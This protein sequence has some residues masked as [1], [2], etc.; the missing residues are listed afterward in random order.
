MFDVAE[1]RK[2]TAALTT[3]MESCDSGEGTECADLDASL[4]HYAGLCCELREAIRQW[5][6]AVFAGRVAFDPEVERLWL[7]EADQLYSHAVEMMV[8]GRLAEIPCY[9]L[10]GKTALGAALWEMER[11][12]KNWTSPK[13]AVGPSARHRGAPTSEAAAEA[14]WKL[15][16]LPPLPADWKPAGPRQ[17]RRFKKL[18]EERSQ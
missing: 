12:L 13:L 11:L 7:A 18:R 2:F 4:L 6:R 16:E 8:Y 3:R 15:S 17:Q 9:M 5:G 1:V 14:R 10:E